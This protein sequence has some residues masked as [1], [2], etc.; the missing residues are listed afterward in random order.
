MVRK[1]I[2]TYFDSPGAENTE[3][4]LKLAKERMEEL[5]I[6]SVVVAST[7]GNHRRQGG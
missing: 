6:T 2:T 4:T 3:E 7:T 1:A 5:G